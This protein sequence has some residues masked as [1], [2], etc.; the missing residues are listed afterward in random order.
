MSAWLHKKSTKEQKKFLSLSA[1]KSSELGLK[2]RQKEQA[3][4][5]KWKEKVKIRGQE[6]EKKHLKATERKTKITSHVKENG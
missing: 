4:R 3:V 2:H 5:A 1:Q 6:I